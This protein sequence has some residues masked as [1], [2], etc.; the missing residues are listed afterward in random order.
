MIKLTSRQTNIIKTLIEQPRPISI[1]GLSKQFNVSER[2]IRYDLKDIEYWLNLKKLNLIKK[3]NVGVWVDLNGKDRNSIKEELNIVEPYEYVLTIKER[4]D[5]II[6]LILL[7][8]KP[9]SSQYIADELQISRNTVINDLKNVKLQLKK[10]NLELK[11]K[12]RFGFYIF[13]EEFSIRKYINNLVFIYVHETELFDTSYARQDNKDIGIALRLIYNSCKDINISDIKNAVKECK[14]VYDFFIP[15]NSYTALITDLMIVIKRIKSGNNIEFSKT[16]KNTMIKLREYTVAKVIGEYLSKMYKISFSEDEIVFIS[17]SLFNNDFKL[18]DSTHNIDK[19]DEHLLKQSVFK[20]I[21]VAENH[22]Y[23]GS[24]IKEKLNQDLLAHMSLTLKKYK[25]G[26]VSKNPLLDEIKQAYSEEFIIAKDMINSFTGVM[27]IELNEDEIGYIAII[28]AA[29][30]EGQ[31]KNQSKKALVVCSTGKGSAK[32][33]YQRIKNTIPE[34]EI[35]GTFSVFELEDYP[36]ILKEA[37][38]I[39]STVYFKTEDKPLIKVSSFVSGSDISKIKS[40]IY[41][42]NNNL[43]NKEAEKEEYV[44]KTLFE[45]IEKYVDKS[46]RDKVKQELNSTLNLMAKDFISASNEYEM[47]EKYSEKTAMSIIEMSEM[48]NEL[49]ENGIV[50][51]RNKNLFPIT[52]HIIMAIPRW[53]AGD[54]TNEVDI[55]KYKNENLEMFSIIEKHLDYISKKYSLNVPETEVVSLMRYLL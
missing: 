53:I 9:V 52:I 13:G 54:Y 44:L 10:Y 33:L 23:L 35:L 1:E 22:I 26:T 31:K 15:D 32:I 48:L 4:Q 43:Y 51:E 34:L 5:I 41:E 27:N 24:E 47:Y 7:S 2:T 16:R 28:L 39:I 46:K 37:D 17:Y 55:E 45:M 3:P 30:L 19:K 11:S 40:F 38:L 8:D 14:K 49:Y 18:K 42:G 20:M 12:A 36:E 6:L 25:I 50:D 21:E 29:Q